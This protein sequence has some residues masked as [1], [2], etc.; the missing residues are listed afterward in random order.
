MKG[1]DVVTCP[2]QVPANAVLQVQDMVKFRNNSTPVMKDRFKGMVQTVWTDTGQ[3]MDSLS[4][5]SE[6]KDKDTNSSVKCFIALFD[7]IRKLSDL[8]K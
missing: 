2:W 5:Q 7:E 8:E 1:L 3:F 4:G 6:G